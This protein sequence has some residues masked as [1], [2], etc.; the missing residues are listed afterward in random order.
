MV[1]LAASICTRSG[2]PLLSRQF[3]PMPRSRVDG[4]LAAFPKLI[5]VNSQHTTVETN[6]VRFVYQPFEELYVLLITNKG[7][8][9]LQDIKTLSLLVRLISSLTPAMSEPAI[10][11]HA[12]DLLCGF[13]EIVSLG[14][15]ENVSLSQVRNVLEGESHEEKIQ[16]IIARNKEAEA[17]EELKRRAKQL[18]MQRREQQRLNQA[19]SRSSVPGGYGGGGSGGYS[20]VPRYEQP[21]ASEYR[22]PSPAVTQSQSTQ[23]PKFTGSGMKLGKKG[24]QSDLI[25]AALGGE[26]DVEMDEPTHSGYGQHEPEPEPVETE[27]SADV[28]DKVE[29][30]SIHV[31]I[32]EQLSL[33]LLRDGG[34][35]SFELKGD[36]DLRITEAAQSKIR[37][38]LSP[39]D[40]SELQFKQHPNVAKFTGNEKVIGLKDASRSFP[41]G[42]G[43]GVLRWRMTG[44]DES[45]VPLNV[46]VWPQPRGD[47]TSDVAVEYE[48]EA[49]HLTLKNVVISIPVPSGSLPSVTGEAD[50]RLSGNSF[51]WTIDTIDSENSNGSLEFRCQGDADAFFPVS[52]G[53]AASGSLADVEVAKAVLIE[54]GEEQTFSQERILTVDKYEIV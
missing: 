47:G 26:Q 1:V 42:Q 34:L 32:K 21:Q 54:N 28:L 22:T 25:S 8:N 2:K 5:P 44:K 39:H 3:R 35:E 13:D 36:L 4:L 49:Q 17:K 31:T 30:D 10:L 48:L 12:F 51:V 11:H 29:Q 43:L 7:S 18:E 6:D 14:Y 23:K 41:V 52:V 38:T 50:W 46:T 40:Y 27:V 33:T 53:F 19:T 9:I 20:S 24:K 45:H 16:E 15:K 37:L